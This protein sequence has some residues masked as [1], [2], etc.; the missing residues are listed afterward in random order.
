MT[1]SKVTRREAV[2]HLWKVILQEVDEYAT[3]ETEAQ[4]MKVD[5]L[6]AL[7]ALGVS[8]DELDQ[9]AT[10]EGLL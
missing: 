7:L 8:Q 6:E 3:S 10:A 1:E 2:E 9:W 4:L 5:G